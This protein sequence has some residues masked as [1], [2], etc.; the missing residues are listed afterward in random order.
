[1]SCGNHATYTQN[2]S[3]IVREAEPFAVRMHILHKRHF[4]CTSVDAAYKLYVHMINQFIQGVEVS[5]MPYITSCPGSSGKNGP[6]IYV[7]T[8]YAHNMCNH[9]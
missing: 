8:T 1:M 6:A 9:A 4:T 7:A 5:Q 2:A 3:Q